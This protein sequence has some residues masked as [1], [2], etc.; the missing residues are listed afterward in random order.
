MLGM[1]RKVYL[2]LTCRKKV[3]NVNDK[4]DFLELNDLQ[5]SLTS[6][7]VKILESLTKFAHLL[8]VIESESPQ[9]YSF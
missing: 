4:S 9:K 5:R 6:H 8:W 2:L 7:L 1:I 3:R